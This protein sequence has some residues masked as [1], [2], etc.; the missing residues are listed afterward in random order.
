M[1]Q[2]L[3]LQRTLSLRGSLRRLDFP[4]LTAWLLPAVLVC[5]LG[6]Q[7]G[8]FDTVVSSQVGIAAWWALLLIVAFGLAPLRFGRAGWVVLG[9][10]IAFAAWTTAS[11]AWTQSSERT[12]SDVS[13]E[14]VYVALAALVF[15]AVGRTAARHALNGLAAGI[16]V[17]AV[18]AL[19]SRL[20]FEW[21]STPA[22][23][24]AV[25]DSARRLA[26]PLNYWNAL[27]DLMA[28]GIP[29]TLRAA[30]GAR[31]IRW[32]AIA[33]AT[34]PLLGLC[35]FLTASRGG[36]IAIAV[37]VAVF[38]V[39]VADRLP[40]LGVVAVSG[41]GTALL[42][43]GANQ[44][45]AVR[46]GLRSALAAHQ[47]NELLAVAIAV[48]VAVGLLVMAV[49]LI[50]RHAVRPRALT[51]SRRR[52]TAVGSIAF[53]LAVMA[54]TALGGFGFLGHEW[55]QFKTP[56][57]PSRLDGANAL[58]RLQNVTGQGR[59]QYWQAAVSAANA[60]PLTGTG[61]GTFAFWWAQFGTLSGGFVRDAHSL[62]IQALGELGYPGL[63]LIS[64]FVA[65]VLVCGVLRA[66]RT[67]DPG[68]RLVL[69]A[70]TAGA[71]AFA[72]A[73]AVEWIWLIP[74]LP[75]AFFVLAGA[76]ATSSVASEGVTLEA[77]ERP[78]PAAPRRPRRVLWIRIAFAAVCLGAAIAIAIPMAAT[79]A[80]RD[81]QALVRSGNLG[82]ALADAR[83]AA[84]LQPYAA[85]PWLQE[86]LVLE[87]ASRIPRAV[88]AAEHATREGPT[89]YD[90]WLV[91][92][93]LQ[94]RDGHAGAA[95][96]DYLR[97]RSLS[98]HS[99]IFRV[100]KERHA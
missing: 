41:T 26:Y 84:S 32:R 94:A 85:S 23:A 91:L 1:E 14:L 16:A 93:R 3:A 50:E 92:S 10:L 25:P 53:L 43:A 13:L 12:M 21:F 66:I 42:I 88:V 80:V 44:R 70:A 11:L 24:Q 18:V 90:N 82:A 96:H 7:G 59:Y 76:I 15:L 78:A 98:P 55:A 72:L 65:F 17:V 8:G 95:L 48:A 69:A 20:H 6:I 2:A 89:D 60:H 97:A 87:V 51:F 61:A 38:V 36:T 57:G 75:I 83:D 34:V 99:P 81:S 100:V 33:G 47:G 52:A 27:A 5:Y 63:L 46:D 31:T 62:Y 73:A 40:A 56:T 30:C 45:A 22:I 74:V 64:G 29:L 67:A 4:A 19:L 37:G 58:Q 54:F 35:A 9:L 49:G 77:P 71:T 68:Q 28:I 79:E 86:A 39:L